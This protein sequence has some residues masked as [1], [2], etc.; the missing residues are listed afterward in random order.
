MKFFDKKK[1]KEHTSSAHKVPIQF[2]VVRHLPVF[3][4][5]ESFLSRLFDMI[6][7]II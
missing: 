5:K 6:R 3:S 7:R 1:L 4:K 2:G